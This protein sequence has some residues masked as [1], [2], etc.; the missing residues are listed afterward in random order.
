MTLVEAASIGTDAY[1]NVHVDFGLHCPMINLSGK[2]ITYVTTSVNMVFGFKTKNHV[3][4][5]RLFCLRY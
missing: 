3:S 4:S 1:V 2:K 5:H